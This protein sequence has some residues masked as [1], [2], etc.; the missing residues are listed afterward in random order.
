[1]EL[2]KYAASFLFEIQRLILVL[3]G[4]TLKVYICVYNIMISLFVWQTH[5]EA[6]LLKMG[7]HIH[8]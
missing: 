2:E 8:D 4:N 5:M 1:M 7:K 3:C 6:S